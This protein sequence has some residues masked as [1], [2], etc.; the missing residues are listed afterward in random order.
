MNS[1]LKNTEE[2]GCELAMVEVDDLAGLASLHTHL[3]NIVEQANQFAID[4]NVDAMSTIQEAGT[5]AVELI[6]KVILSKLNDGD[7]ALE[8]WPRR[9]SASNGSWKR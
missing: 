1:L 7:L 8:R 2:L 3:L 5:K 4:S 9:Q 6:E